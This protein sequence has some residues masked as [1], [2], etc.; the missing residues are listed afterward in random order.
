MNTP[1]N[2]KTTAKINNPERLAFWQE[3]F[4]GDT[5]PIYSFVPSVADLPGIPG[6]AVYMLDLGAITAD[7]RQRLIAGIARKF[8]LS[9]EEVTAGLYAHGVPILADDV[10]VSSTDQGLLMSV[11]LDDFGDDEEE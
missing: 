11:V 8:D 5:V 3:V 10:S 1:T 2:W 9:I 7:Q 6:A 4:G